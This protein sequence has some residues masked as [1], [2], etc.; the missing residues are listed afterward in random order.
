MA[1]L[2]TEDC[3]GIFNDREEG[4]DEVD[5]APA[6]YGTRGI[7]LGKDADIPPKYF[8]HKIFSPFSEGMQ[9]FQRQN[10]KPP[11]L[12]LL[13][14]DWG[15]TMSP[16]VAGEGRL[17]LVC[18]EPLGPLTLNEDHAKK[19]AET[20]MSQAKDVKCEPI[21]WNPTNLLYLFK[22]NE[23]YLD[24]GKAFSN[25]QL[26][27]VM[28]FKV[29]KIEPA[30]F[31]NPPKCLVE[32]EAAAGQGEELQGALLHVIKPFSGAFPFL[33]VREANS[34]D[35]GAA[36]GNN[37]EEGPPAKNRRTEDVV[38][39]ISV[40]LSFP[41]NMQ[42]RA[43]QVTDRLGS[44]PWKRV[45][46]PDQSETDPAF[47]VDERNRLPAVGVATG[48]TSAGVMVSV[49]VQEEAKFAEMAE[50]YAKVLGTDAMERITKEGQSKVSLFPL[51]PRAEFYVIRQPGLNLR[52]A[53]NLTLY[54]QVS[55]FTLP[56]RRVG[57]DHLEVTDPEGN[58]VMLFTVG[59]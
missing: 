44:S 5:G 55:G 2:V 27:E 52:T 33:T 12:K 43:A 13:H 23:A 8:L 29:I 51:S 3:E 14:K 49:F 32:A 16:T 10:S 20:I 58:K 18:L 59:K 24:L 38:P 35:N 19:V 9:S 22:D 7:Y 40:T 45:N 48:A 50:F 11:K 54:F 53:S 1:S 56:G 46:F 4:L 30:M 39:P 42:S 37:R 25:G 28:G 21:R 34:T 26:D 15:H 47:Y 57:D 17:G 41:G 6:S 31:V 36:A